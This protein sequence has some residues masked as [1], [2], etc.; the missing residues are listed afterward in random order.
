MS[1]LAG[2]GLAVVVIGAA[3]LALGAL[4]RLPYT[5]A[6]AGRGV[7][8]LS[9]RVRGERVQQCR[10]LSAEELEALPL[11]MRRPEAC[12]GRIAPYRLRVVI[13][14][15]LV[16]D[17]LVSAAGAKR[18]RPIYVFRDFPLTPGAHQVEITFTR[19]GAPEAD[20]GA[21]PA[22][23]GATPEGGGAPPERGGGEAGGGRTG[24]AP[25]RLALRTVVEIRPARIA[26]VTY[27]PAE[28]ALVLRSAEDRER[29]GS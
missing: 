14:G 20:G 21:A 22:P 17:A 16:E 12:E 23:G 18:D 8:R 7:L 29:S 11:H 10:R 24:A 25:V 26:L 15:D 27:D 19:E 9:W 1:T 6:D 5:A 13:D 3:V 28:D 4:S 2:R